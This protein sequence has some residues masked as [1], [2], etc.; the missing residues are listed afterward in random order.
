MIPGIFGFITF[1]SLGW[2]L[3]S[4]FTAATQ[5]LA[6]LAA[7]T[8]PWPA[9][10]QVDP[11]NQAAFL[12]KC[13]DNDACAPA[14]GQLWL[15]HYSLIPILV[16][17]PALIATLV[18]VRI[19]TGRLV[20]GK[21]PGEGHWGT[22]QEL[23][24]EGYIKTKKNTDVRGYFGIHRDSKRMIQIPERVRFSH[25]LVIGG[26]GAR[27]STGY[28][29]Q[30]IIQDLK[31]GLNIIVFD[32]KYPDPRGGF[33]D[34]VSI[35]AERYGYNVQLMLPYDQVTHRYS[36]LTAAKTETG[37]REVASMIVPT[38]EGSDGAAFYRNN[39]RL[40]L[41]A[42]ILA[43]ARM[44]NG[45]LKD[46]VD[47]LREGVRGVNDFVKD[48]A[49][50]DVTSMMKTVLEGTDIEKQK[51]IIN[52][53][54]GK[55]EIFGDPDLLAF[56][57]LSR[58]PRENI[59][60]RR[61]ANEKT[62]LYIGVPQQKIA[63][64]GGQTFLQL[65]KRSIDKGLGEISRENAGVFPIPISYYLDEFP[66][67]GPLP[68]VGADF[69]TMRS[70]RLSYH[71]TVQNMAQGAAV[72]GHQEWESFYRSNF[73]SVLI[74]PRYIRFGDADLFSKFAGNLTVNEQSTSDSKSS[75]DSRHSINTREVSRPL[76]STEEMKEWPQAEG[77]AFLNG[78]APVRVVLPRLDEPNV[79]S[80]KNPYHAD[81]LAIPEKLNP[82]EWVRD[83]FDR[84]HVDR[85]RALLESKLQEA[86]A[87]IA[88]KQERQEREART[89]EFH[90]PQVS[91]ASTP[92]STP[93]SAPPPAAKAAP[94][95]QPAAAG[96]N[97]SVAVLERPTPPPQAAPKQAAKRPAPPPPPPA[98]PAPVKDGPKGTRRFNAFIHTLIKER[99]SASVIKVGKGKRV[100]EL[101][102]RSTPT[103]EAWLAP[104]YELLVTHSSFLA[105][106]GDEIAL[107]RTGLQHLTPNAAGYYYRLGSKALTRQQRAVLADTSTGPKQQLPLSKNK[108]RA[109]LRKEIAHLARQKHLTW[110][111]GRNAPPELIAPVAHLDANR[112]DAC[113]AYWREHGLAKV[114]DGSLHISDKALIGMPERAL[115][116]L[117]AIPSE[118]ESSP[119]KKAAPTRKRRRKKKVAAADEDSRRGASEPNTAPPASVAETASAPAPEDAAPPAAAPPEH[120][121][122]RGNDPKVA[123][124][125]LYDAPL[126]PEEDAPVAQTSTTKP[127]IP[128]DT[129]APEATRE[130]PE[131]TREAPEAPPPPPAAPPET[132]S[133]TEDEPTETA[134]KGLKGIPED[135]E[136][137]VV[138]PPDAKAAGPLESA[139]V[140]DDPF[141]R[142]SIEDWILENTTRLSG[143]PDAKGLDPQHV[144]GSYVGERLY[145][146]R[147]L[148]LDILKASNIEQVPK[149]IPQIRRRFAAEEADWIVL[150]PVGMNTSEELMIG[151]A[152]EG[153]DHE[154]DAIRSDAFIR[155]PLDE[156]AK[157][158]PHVP[159]ATVEPEESKSGRVSVRI[160]I[161]TRKPTT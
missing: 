48:A 68:D 61:F 116:L 160:M 98:P 120:K 96:S 114:R 102:F 75:L 19:S 151:G 105:R 83:Y 62:I 124:Q 153:N 27:K 80:Y 156:I 6:V 152:L 119:T 49:D 81:Y 111:K 117:P 155:V 134:A 31:D 115:A 3:Y 139:L 101:A 24:R 142:S 78:V 138:A 65:M 85:K 34:M 17:V 158:L 14:L 126:F 11:D 21:K 123:A 52:G 39:E 72:Y 145:V 4:V 8:P 76:M 20:K 108:I 55:L 107:T 12:Y 66:N 146:K 43:A 84:I 45:S 30:N 69:A 118:P 150:D 100:L 58:D 5:S 73:Q 143:H 147:E 136:R 127:T 99:V 92:A 79:R 70:R 125:H 91:P 33:F 23:K 109:A 135:L 60:M 7:T 1:A 128:S 132:P 53:L 36:F 77:V 64:S 74:F 40:I 57:Q 9:Y 51:G 90:R 15:H 97:T 26:P 67:F 10:L 38:G 46:I 93:A 141:D 71:V 2:A 82:Y 144:F 56:G 161:V 88:A 122:R 44:E 131:A 22:T 157:V 103:L 54:L 110:S 63:A 47:A 13:L 121:K 113:G 137:P 28:H 95:T 106:R 50:P 59:D 35:A 112:L 154:G 25:C 148:A 41:T 149:G 37:A 29:K 159:W 86:N 129:E 94:A 89:R 18:A 130:A 133:P 140:V 42:L 87:R 32:L 104:E 16:F